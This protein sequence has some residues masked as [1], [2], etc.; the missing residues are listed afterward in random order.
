MPSFVKWSVISAY[1]FSSLTFYCMR[2][3]YISKMH[4]NK[5][6]QINRVLPTCINHAYK[7]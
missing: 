5:F 3:F 2:Q 7:H 6:F 4:L 1:G